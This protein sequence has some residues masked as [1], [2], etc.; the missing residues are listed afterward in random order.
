MPIRT[1]IDYKPILLSLEQRLIEN[2]TDAYEGTE[3]RRAIIDSMSTVISIDGS[4]AVLEV[5]SNVL[6]TFKQSEREDDVEFTDIGGQKTVE[7]GVNFKHAGLRVGASQLADSGGRVANRVGAWTSSAGSEAGLLP[8]REFLQIIKENRKSVLDGLPLFGTAHTLPFGTDTYSNQHTGFDVSV[9]ATSTGMSAYEAA[10]ANFAKAL[11]Q[12]N[13]IPLD[14]GL[15]RPYRSVRVLAPSA[16]APRLRLITGS[17]TLPASG[18]G[19]VAN[20][21]TPGFGTEVVEVPEL[22]AA[23]TK[24]TADDK[25]YFIV[26]SPY[27]GNN[28]FIRVDRQGLAINTFGPLDSAELN[29]IQVFEWIA[30]FRDRLVPG[31]PGCIHVFRP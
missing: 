11:S 3:S 4:S 22:G 26:A 27:A 30:R 20:T 18:G 1:N 29:R 23:F 24:V 2:I 10:A 16:L 14:S 8:Y 28:A 6:V 19:V 17:V 12:V 9:D 13:Q 7:V 15:A 25:R 5:S 21:Y 31:D